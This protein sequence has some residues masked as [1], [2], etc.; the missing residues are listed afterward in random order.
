[1]RNLT[2][3]AMIEDGAWAGWE[4]SEGCKGGQTVGGIQCGF[5]R[6]VRRRTCRRTLGG[7]YCQD[8]EGKEMKHDD[9]YKSVECRRGTCPGKIGMKNNLINENLQSGGLKATVMP[10]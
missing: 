7:K 10:K 9:Q 2:R 8:D 6:Q 3:C 5:G 4:D 1:M